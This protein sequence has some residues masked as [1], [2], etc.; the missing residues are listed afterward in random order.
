MHLIDR[1][2]KGRVVL[3][4][5]MR[6]RLRIGGSCHAV[7]AAQPNRSITMHSS[8]HRLASFV[9]VGFGGLAACGAQAFQGEQSPLPTPP[10]QSTMSRATVQAQAVRPVQ[11]SNGG[12]GVAV[13]RSVA[14][15]ASVRAG[16][17]AIAAKGAGAYGEM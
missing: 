15:R 8:F 9:L 6:E 10:F 17:R 4:N 12:T 3:S 16:A 7:V 13:V 2:P 1:S 11:F 5:P 14:D